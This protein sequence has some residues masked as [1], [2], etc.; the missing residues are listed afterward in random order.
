VDGA[1]STWTNSGNLYV[2]YN[3]AWYVLW[4]YANGTLRITNGGAVSNA[5]GWI[6]HEASS[7]GMVTVDGVGSTWTNSGSLTIG[8]GYYH[9]GN[10]TLS[11]TGG[12]AVSNNDGIIGNLSDSS[13]LVTVSGA[14]STWTNTGDLYVGNSGNGTLSITGGGNVSNTCGFIG[15]TSGSK[16]MVSVDG[17]G[18][19]WTTSSYL[20]IGFSGTGFLS[21]TNG[22]MVRT[23]Y[24][25]DIQSAG[26]VTVDGSGSIWATK[27]GFDI[28]GIL[29][30][31]NGGTVSTYGRVMVENSSMI[32]VDGAGSTWTNGQGLIIDNAILKIANGGAVRDTSAGYWPST[33]VASN[34][35]DAGTVTIDGDNSIWTIST[36]LALGS[37]GTGTVIQ[38]GGSVSVGDTLYLGYFSGSTGIY[39]LNG[40]VLAIRGLAKGSDT[41][42]FNFGGGTLTTTAS[43]SSDV[44]MTLT[45]TGGG[46]TVN[47]AGYAATLSGVLSGTASA[48][49]LTKAGSGTLTLSGANTYAGLTT[50]KAGVLK[51]AGT[52][53]ATPVAWNPVLNLAGADVQG[54]T[55]AFSYTG[56]TSPAS[57]ILSIL[58]TS[59]NTASASHFNA[60]YG[61]KI[62]SSTAGTINC[63]LGWIDDTTNKQVN[64]M[65]TIYGDADLSGV[66]GASDLS[67]VLTNFGKPGVW[68]DGDFDY[69]GVV[70]ASDLSAVLT[71]FGQSP[72]SSLNISP[73][74]LNPEAIGILN[75]AG[76]TVVP[77][78]GTLALLAA[79][80]IG[81]IAYAWR[82][83]K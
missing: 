4:G 42:I 11:I 71:N 7:T 46:A 23:N 1:G 36:H 62:F 59:Y 38:N 26:T 35:A 6:G 15:N 2:A 78:P 67:T 32:T 37:K 63:G 9:G 56:G 3:E 17:A 10:G 73:Y 64:I 51:L 12:G 82:K 74:N 47:T 50:V 30:I 69:S 44:P 55:L 43:L 22:G 75:A 34:S 79:G 45:G 76:I 21:I 53:A 65:Y 48:G 31:F 49:G 60:S 77:E 58:T 80:L 14:G 20:Y 16:G 70:G 54:G 66:V 40:G 24:G 8:G 25:A 29:N 33:Y 52:S 19:M 72:P 68:S 41:A 28:Y 39:N 83:R 81:L 13:G 61:A 5:N 18:S 27:Y 57:T